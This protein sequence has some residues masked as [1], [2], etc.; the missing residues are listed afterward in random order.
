METILITSELVSVIREQFRINWNG[1]HG[2]SHWARFYDI[3]MKLAE[4]KDGV[5]PR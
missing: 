2:I 5:G 1:I 3:G 4:D